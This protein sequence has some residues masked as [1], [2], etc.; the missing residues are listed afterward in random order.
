MIY[1]KEAL[2]DDRHEPGCVLSSFSRCC[3]F[4]EGLVVMNVVVMVVYTH[5]ELRLNMRM[6]Y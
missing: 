2:Q 1:S 6:E 4:T 5:G 3:R